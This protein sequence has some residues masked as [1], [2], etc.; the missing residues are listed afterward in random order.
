VKKVQ[1]I[2]DFSYVRIVGLQLKL[3]VDKFKTSKRT[4]IFMCY[5]VNVWI[6]LLMV[7]W[8]TKICMC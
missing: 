5:T 7:L 2:T 3:S 1:L 4:C 8:M 6:Y